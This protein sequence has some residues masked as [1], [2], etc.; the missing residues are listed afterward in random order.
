MVT[1]K[2]PREK[3]G[4]LWN[5]M[6][7]KSS[8]QDQAGQNQKW[9]D[10]RHGR[11]K[12]IPT[13]HQTTTGQVV[14]THH[15]YA[16]KP[17][18][19][20]GIQHQ[21]LRLESE[22][23]TKKTMERLRGRHPQNSR[24]VPSPGHPPC[25]WQ[26]AV[27]PRD[28]YRYKRKKKVKVSHTNTQ[29]TGWRR[30]G[31]GDTK[32][33]LQEKP[34]QS[35]SKRSAWPLCKTPCQNPPKAIQVKHQHNT[36]LTMQTGPEK[37][38]SRVGRQTA[39]AWVYRT[40]VSQRQTVLAWLYRT[41][42]SQRQTVLAW[43]YRTAVSQRQTVLAWLY[44]TAVSQRQTVLAWLYRTAVSHRQTVLA[45]LYRTAVSQRQTVLTWLYRTAVSQRQTVLAWLYRTAVSQ[46]QTVLAW[47]YR[48]AVSQRHFD[49]GRGRVGGVVRVVLQWKGEG[50]AAGIPD[51][52]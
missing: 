51:K 37:V 47:L 23:K 29:K 22:R 41:A 35:N 6:P 9:G 10:T 30:E 1:N 15:T 33:L 16:Y 25:F 45:W 39:K 34:A 8:K 5:E 48:T 42:V 24:D 36:I 14:R 32:S 40:A 38:F 21:V 13:A 19:P 18:L 31:K 2:R 46:R 4:H 26:T 50:V 12:T 3:T 52:W 28:A 7:E 49:V 20:P 43:L 17:T 27:S 11:S 44:R